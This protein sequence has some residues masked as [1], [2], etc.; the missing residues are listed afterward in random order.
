M[1]SCP[2]FVFQVSKH[3]NPLR[4]NEAQVKKSGPTFLPDNA[5]QFTKWSLKFRTHT[6][7]THKSKNCFESKIV[8]EHTHTH[9]RDESTAAPDWQLWWHTT[10]LAVL[11]AHE[12]PSLSLSLRTLYT[13]K[14]KRIQRSRHTY[15]H[16][17]EPTTQTNNQR[18]R[19]R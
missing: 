8:K 4:K 2:S 18:R 1:F 14:A 6:Q 15:I 5:L 11:V 12:S 13:R 9:T 3:T 7:Q 17:D 10:K 19:R 16:T